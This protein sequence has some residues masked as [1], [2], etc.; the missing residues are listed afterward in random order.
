[1]VILYQ[2]D[3][4]H[5][6]E[7][8]MRVLEYVETAEPVVVSGFLDNKVIETLSP[9]TEDFS[10]NEFFSYVDI[11]H[12]DVKSL[13]KEYL[14][15]Y[16]NFMIDGEEYIVL[17]ADWKELDTYERLAIN[18]PR[19]YS[20]TFTPEEQE[21]IHNIIKSDISAICDCLSGDFRSKHASHDGMMKMF[22]E[23]LTAVEIY[24]KTL[25]K[26]S[27]IHGKKAS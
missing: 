13:C 9:S 1:M 22:S 4:I 20:N 18:D 27:V 12:L 23:L 6:V 8:L 24:K 26:G 16:R 3:Q 2:N 7:D 15:P 21:Y 17:V 5:S 11:G 19:T 25:P 10:S 14:I